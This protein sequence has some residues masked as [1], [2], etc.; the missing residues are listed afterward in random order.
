MPM[1]AYRQ[2][3]H[4]IVHFDLPGVDPASIDLTVEKN[5]LTVSAERQWQPARTRGRRRRTARRATSVASCSSARALT[6]SGSRRVR[7]RRAH[8]DDPGRRAGQAPQGRDRPGNGK[9]QP[10]RPTRPRHPELTPGTAPVGHRAVPAH[11]RSRPVLFRLEYPP[12]GTSST[13]GAAAP[14]EFLRRRP[15]IGERAV[16]TSTGMPY[17]D[18]AHDRPRPNPDVG[19]AGGGPRLPRWSLEPMSA[20]PPTSTSTESGT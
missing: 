17:V 18:A 8:R 12:P 19:R 11:R 14:F 20:N 7:Q 10:S 1:D 5:V 9:A 4:F 15:G 2:G 3:D 16:T 13:L 6:P